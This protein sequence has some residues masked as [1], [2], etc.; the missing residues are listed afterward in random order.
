MVLVISILTQCFAFF[1]C[2]MRLTAS[3]VRTP[4]VY[5]M[6]WSSTGPLA[7]PW[8]LPLENAD[9]CVTSPKGNLRP[10]K[11]TITYTQA[12]KSD[13]DFAQEWQITVPESARAIKM[14]ATLAD[15]HTSLI[16]FESL[17]HTVSQAGPLKHFSSCCPSHRSRP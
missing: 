10:Q 2:K 13:P 15:H 12:W 11:G 5:S 7:Q 17:F 1:I 16:V 3:P 14:N 9:H 4:Y 6:P 8:P